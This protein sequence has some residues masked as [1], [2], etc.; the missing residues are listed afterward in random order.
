[1]KLFRLSEIL[2]AI[3]LMNCVYIADQAH[4]Q[5]S[6]ATS[7]SVIETK[8]E[9]SVKLVANQHYQVHFDWF[10]REIMDV[11]QLAKAG[12]LVPISENSKVIGFRLFGIR[13]ES[14][15]D[16]LGL[17]NGDLILSISGQVLSDTEQLKKI[18]DW[19][20]EQT[21]IQIQV[22]RKEQVMAFLVEVLR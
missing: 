14:S 5:D 2:T 18:Y 3:L 6:S 20:I 12:R 11:H 1:M 7:P 19:A 4:A 10:K 15:L 21:K 13:K 22:K 9:S 8:T 17:K 16:L